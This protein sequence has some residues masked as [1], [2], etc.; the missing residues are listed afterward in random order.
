MT[1]PTTASPDALFKESVPPE[2]SSL[3]GSNTSSEPTLPFVICGG[4]RNISV[5]KLTGLWP[6]VIRG[7]E[8]TL[9]VRVCIRGS[10][11]G[12]GERGGG[13]ELA[14]IF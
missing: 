12:G 8:Y 11:G 1:S 14:L 10:G 5:R 7:R 9:D 6:G 2:R 3:L 13:R 4:W